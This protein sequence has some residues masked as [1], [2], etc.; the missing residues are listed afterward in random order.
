MPGLIEQ[1]KHGI[2]IDTSTPGS[3]SMSTSRPRFWR[4]DVTSSLSTHNA[5]CR[6]WPNTAHGP[7]EHH[8]NEYPERLVHALETRFGAMECPCPVRIV[9][10]AWL[11]IAAASVQVQATETVRSSL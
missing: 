11:P 2:G 8:G 4:S 10:V 6:H 1:T 9:V 7:A 3:G 5:I